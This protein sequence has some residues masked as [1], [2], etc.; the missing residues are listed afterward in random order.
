[1]HATEDKQV[2]K[3]VVEGIIPLRYTQVYAQ[4]KESWKPIKDGPGRIVI[5]ITS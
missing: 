4:V 2:S 3:R 1:V 5:S